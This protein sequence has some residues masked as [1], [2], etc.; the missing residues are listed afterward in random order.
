M[1]DDVAELI[2]MI[3]AH[4]HHE[5]LRQFGIV[6]ARGVA[7]RLA[8]IEVERKQRR[9][10]IVLEALDAVAD[11][12]R[13]QRLVEQIEKGLM[14]IERGDDEV[15][16]PDEFAVAGL[17]A[18]GAAAF[19]D[20]ALRLGHHAD[21][22]AGFANRGFQ[23]ARERRGAAA[24]HLRLGRAREQGRDVMAEA[25]HPQIDLAQPVE[26]QQARL[27]GR[28]L[29]FLLHEL[30]RRQRAHLEQPPSGRAAL[31]Q[32]AALVRR[33]R[34]RL[35]FPRQDVLHD[36]HELMVP[37]PQRFGIAGA[38]LLERSRG[39]LDVGPPVEHA[40]VAGEQRDVQLGL[41]VVRAV[42]LE[43]EVRVPRHRR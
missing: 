20:D 1:A 37:A 39:A 14:R 11:L 43:L 30:E 27:H 13:H 29:E 21:V 7:R 26:E 5:G 2:E 24:R 3:E 42:T 23:R 18:D 34:R 28:M 31:E 8:Q 6:R 12:A 32:L 40:A 33:Q 19:D 16:G 38:E 4:D 9:Q 10:Q 25:A 35:R 15:P 22:A 41:D 17:D 36:R